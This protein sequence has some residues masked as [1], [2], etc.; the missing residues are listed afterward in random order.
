[1]FL[2]A[3]YD[4]THREDDPRLDLDLA[5]PGIVKVLTG[6]DGATYP[7]LPWEPKEAFAELA[8]IYGVSTR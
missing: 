4:H 8:G 5:S 6:R 2:F 1:M 3:L 7:G